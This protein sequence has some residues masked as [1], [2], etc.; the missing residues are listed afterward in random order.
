MRT[1]IRG[2]RTVL[3]AEPECVAVKEPA[4]YSP[5]QRKG[6]REREGDNRRFLPR[7]G[8]TFAIT[9]SAYARS[10]SIFCCSGMSF[11]P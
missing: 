9:L 6:K 5:A 7:S 10:A 1:V 2:L 11:P 8:Q 4:A 3:A